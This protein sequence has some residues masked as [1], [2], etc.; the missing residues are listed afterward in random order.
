MNS[1]E[2]NSKTFVPITSKNSASVCVLQCPSLHKPHSLWPVEY[3][4]YTVHDFNHL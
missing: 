1:K 3:I 2:E 4:L